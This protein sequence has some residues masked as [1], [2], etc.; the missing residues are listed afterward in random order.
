MKKNEEWWAAM[1][2]SGAPEAAAKAA[3]ESAHDWSSWRAAH[4]RV[5]ALQALRRDQSM[6]GYD[7]FAA[8]R[9]SELLDGQPSHSLVAAHCGQHPD[10][11]RW[12]E[13][14]VRHAKPEHLAVLRR[15]TP[16]PTPRKQ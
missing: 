1:A 9:L 7:S 13:R 2:R 4:A 15:L 8:A 10:T 14:A 12:G 11:R 3:L 6:Y 5:V 16:E